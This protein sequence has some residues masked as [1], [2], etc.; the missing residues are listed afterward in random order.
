MKNL[1]FIPVFLM[2]LFM[3][4]Q[5]RANDGN[6]A[7]IKPEAA[8]AYSIHAIK[9]ADKFALA[10]KNN[11]DN[12]VTIE[13]YDEEGKQVF[14][15]VQYKDEMHKVYDLHNIGSGTYEVV[16]RSGDFVAKEELVL[17][18]EKKKVSAFQAAV[19]PD[20]HN[21]EKMRLAFS[22]AEGDVDIE[23]KD[24]SGYVYYSGTV[25][26][27]SNYNQVFDLANL[28]AGIY[29]I[30]FTMNGVTVSKSYAVE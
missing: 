22:N 28:S 11:T 13:I 24:N 1:R 25:S 27:A 12:K 3:A 29:T 18:M 4:I 30:N 9:N 6:T 15:D 21:G 14:R 8:F 7:L 26:D 2:V 10:F 23:I 5:A 17:G 16:I 19:F 20:A